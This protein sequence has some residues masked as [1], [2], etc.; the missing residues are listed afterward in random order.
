MQ[1]SENPLI[2]ETNASQV[3]LKKFERKSE[4]NEEKRTDFDEI[5]KNPVKKIFEDAKILERLGKRNQE[6]YITFQT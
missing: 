2:E 5:M 6:Q 1:E 4:K 3:D